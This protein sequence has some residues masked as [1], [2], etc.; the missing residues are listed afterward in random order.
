MPSLVGRICGFGAR[1]AALA[2]LQSFDKPRCDL[3]ENLLRYG[4]GEASIVYM[5]GEMRTEQVGAGRH[6]WGSAPPQPPF[7][8]T[9]RR[10]NARSGP[11]FV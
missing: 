3:R 7:Y 4:C 1:N 8:R 11:F 6:W 5:R 9:S 10:E 2:P